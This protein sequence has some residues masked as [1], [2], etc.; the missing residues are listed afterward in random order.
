MIL[1]GGF[2]G[3]GFNAGFGMSNGAVSL[4]VLE[5]CWLVTDGVLNERGVKF[6]SSGLAPTKGLLDPGKRLALGWILNSECSGLW[7]LSFPIICFIVF[8]FKERHLNISDWFG[9]SRWKI[10]SP[11]SH[12]LPASN[13]NLPC[14]YPYRLMYLYGQVAYSLLSFKSLNSM[15]VV[16]SK[17]RYLVD[18]KPHLVDASEVH[19]FTEKTPSPD[20]Q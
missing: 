4:S 8:I 11:V 16:V 9:C 17:S 5:L 14:L 6:K 10:P 13:V 3:L 19:I 2:C 18:S 7:R 20:E 15:A 12:F 1:R